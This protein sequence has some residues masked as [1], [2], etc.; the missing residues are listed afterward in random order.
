MGALNAL[1]TVA[2]KSLAGRQLCKAVDLFKADH[3][4]IQETALTVK[5]LLASANL[6]RMR[7]GAT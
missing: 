7:A 1:H 6:H 3:V 5:V 2:S 4:A